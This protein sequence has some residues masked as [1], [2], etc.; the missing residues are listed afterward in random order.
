M[1]DWKKIRIKGI[2]KI[3]K[4]VAEFKICELNKGPYCNF[5]IKIYENNEGVFTGY[6]NLLIKDELGDFYCAVGHGRTIESVLEDTIDW[7][8]KMLSRKENWEEADFAYADSF[9]F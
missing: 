8:F 7:Y 4:C 2:A 9:D 3:E 6:T 1:D 5:K